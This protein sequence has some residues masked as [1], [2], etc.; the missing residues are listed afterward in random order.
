MNLCI[1]I[2]ILLVKSA[3]FA[4]VPP[5]YG[6]N[7]DIQAAP[8][9]VVNVPV[10][11]TPVQYASLYLTINFTFVHPFAT[12]PRVGTGITQLERTIGLTQR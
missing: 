9:T 11:G 12:T 2:A 3:H 7:T 4:S 6:I 5:T 1:G 10:G 8:Y